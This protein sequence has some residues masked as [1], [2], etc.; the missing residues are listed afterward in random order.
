MFH[1]AN[2]YSC[3]QTESMGMSRSNAFNY[4]HDNN[5]ISIAYS[6]MSSAVKNYSE[7]NII[8]NLFQQ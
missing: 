5:G 3:F 2:Q 8:E 4:K 7:N 6:N 1:V